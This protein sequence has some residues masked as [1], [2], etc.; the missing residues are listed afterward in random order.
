MILA[1]HSLE[2][3]HAWENVFSTFWEKYEQVNPSHPLYVDFEATARGRC[4]PYF[5]HGDEG[6]GQRRVPLMIES[7]QPCISHRGLSFTNE[8]TYLASIKYD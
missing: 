5:L 1:G 3:R 4:I 8:S 7:F 6:R 2:D